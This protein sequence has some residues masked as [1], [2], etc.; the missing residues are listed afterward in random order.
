M[1][2]HNLAVKNQQDTPPLQLRPYTTFELNSLHIAT[3]II[4]W[5]VEIH[6]FRKW[7]ERSQGKPILEVA[8]YCCT[9]FRPIMRL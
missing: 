9:I 3:W 8:T 4:E 7:M 6:I 5:T 2:A 1:L